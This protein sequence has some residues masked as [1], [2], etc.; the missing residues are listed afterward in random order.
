MKSGGPVKKVKTMAK[1]GQMGIPQTGPTGPNYQGVDTMQKGGMIKKQDG[2][3]VG[4]YDEILKRKVKKNLAG[5]TVTKQ[6]SRSYDPRSEEMSV[7]KTKTV[8][9]KNAKAGDTV[10]QKS[11]SK[12]TLSQKVLDNQK[13]GGSV[14]K[15][16]KGGSAFGMLS[17]KAGIDK[18]PGKTFA[19]KIAGAKKKVKLTK[20]QFGG[21]TS[22][23]TV[24]SRTLENLGMFI[25]G[26]LGTALAARKQNQPMS[27]KKKERVLA[28]QQKKAARKSK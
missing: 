9:P 28:R 18:N 25:G 1:G 14:K 19:D 3:R 23:N 12:I 2:G 10:R 8:T 26:G 27:E 24:P 20:K 7:T 13:V 16:A 4:A 21:A 11:K 6:T 22:N 17:V 15:M 5:S